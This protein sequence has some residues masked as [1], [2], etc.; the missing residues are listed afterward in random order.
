MGTTVV[1]LMMLSAFVF[2]DSHNKVDSSINRKSNTSCEDGWEI[3]Y[4]K[5]NCSIQDPKDQPWK[6]LIEQDDHGHI[7]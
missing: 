3:I 7:L 1:V 6:T 5:F 2:A 4:E